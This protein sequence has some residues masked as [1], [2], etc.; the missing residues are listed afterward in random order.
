[1]SYNCDSV[2]CPICGGD[3]RGDKDEDGDCF[4]M[5]LDC[6]YSDI[7]EDEENPYAIDDD[8]FLSD[9]DDPFDV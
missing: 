5:C 2:R 4:W 3:M 1:V 9:N 8:E 7:I 6:G